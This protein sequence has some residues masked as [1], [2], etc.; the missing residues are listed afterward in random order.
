MP[1]RPFP[2]SRV[3]PDARVLT[4]GSLVISAVTWLI[5]AGSTIA[6]S[7]R[8]GLGA[9]S[10]DH[11]VVICRN[12]LALLRQGLLSG[13]PWLLSSVICLARDVWIVHKPISSGTR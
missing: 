2:E 3:A 1:E 10:L 13:D 11:G 5:E 6:G 9:P 8:R 4:C 12:Q 7:H